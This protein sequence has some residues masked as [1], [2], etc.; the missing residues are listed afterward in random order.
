MGLVANAETAFK[1]ALENS[2]TFTRAAKAR[3]YLEMIAIAQNPATSAA[4]MG[5][6]ES[7]LKGDANH[8]PALMAKASL[9]EQKG[10]LKSAKIGYEKVLARYADF[11]P[12]KRQLA[13]YH[14]KSNEDIAQGVE[15]ATKAREAFPKD[16]EVAKALGILFA[17]QG[18]HAR[19]IAL[20]QESARSLNKDGEVMFHLGMAQH[21][22]NQPDSAKTSLQRALD[23]GL[24]DNLT[25]EARRALSPTK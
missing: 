5:K 16:P 8:V 6:V 24:P 7:L 18:N 10:N 17:R 1:N 4:T 19:A 25:I 22:S 12:A 2:S 14:S 21:K 11:A 9:D 15:L 13:I 20:L 23:L 3:E